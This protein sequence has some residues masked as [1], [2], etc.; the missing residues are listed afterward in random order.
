MSSQATPILPYA[1]DRTPPGHHVR[2]G[3]DEHGRFE[4]VV[5]PPAVWRLVLGP[6][7]G[8]AFLTLWLPFVVA[9]M[10]VT[11]I[12]SAMA[13][14]LALGVVCA[15]GGG[16]LSALM[17][18]VRAARG[19]R[20]PFRLTVDQSGFRITDP[21]RNTRPADAARGLQIDRVTFARLFPLQLGFAYGMI[22]LLIK[23]DE[24][25]AISCDIPTQCDQALAPA[26][27]WLQAVFHVAPVPCA[28]VANQSPTAAP[29]AAEHR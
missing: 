29:A 24:G 1:A 5:P 23:T 4:L 10:V 19:G 13:G 20:Q 12:D 15:I 9:W 16:W 11:F 17:M 21:R 18:I 2:W 7:L 26:D 25:R 28:D 27:D 22:R 3:Q 14:C 6:A 8:L